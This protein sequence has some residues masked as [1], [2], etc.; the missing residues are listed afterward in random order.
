MGGYQYCKCNFD[1]NNLEVDVG[2]NNENIQKNVENTKSANL[3]K[4]HSQDNP[5]NLKFGKVICYC[6]F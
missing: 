5:Q 1:L 3:Y 2:N 6:R 4:V